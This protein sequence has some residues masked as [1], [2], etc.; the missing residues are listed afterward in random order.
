MPPASMAVA[1]STLNV[2]ATCK[3]R[4]AE[5]RCTGCKVRLAAEFY[6]HVLEFNN[7]FSM[8]VYQSISAQHYIYIYLSFYCIHNEQCSYYC[9]RECQVMHWKN[10][11]KKM[12]PALQTIMDG[13]EPSPIS[14][15]MVEAMKEEDLMKKVNMAMKEE[16]KRKMKTKKKKGKKKVASDDDEPGLALYKKGMDHVAG[17]VRFLEDYPDAELDDTRLDPEKGYRLIREAA[18]MGCK[19]AQYMLA[20]AYLEGE[21]P[22][23]YFFDQCSSEEAEKERAKWIKMAAE[24][25][26]AEACVTYANKFWREGE[27]GHPKDLGEAM[28]W[29][30]RAMVRGVGDGL[31]DPYGD[32]LSEKS[33]EQAQEDLNHIA[34]EAFLY[35]YASVLHDGHPDEEREEKIWLSAD[36][37]IGAAL[38]EAQTFVDA[39]GTTGQVGDDDE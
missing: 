29:L 4:C 23:G 28:V 10:G 27:C 22:S 24:N 13:Y 14:K 26:H 21:Y 31:P 38:V 34:R 3:K 19:G 36:C 1:L 11:H 20:L 9:S 30:R 25:G 15:K 12:C 18:E 17:A 32:A 6:H 8:Y 2:C 33:F 7:Y 35:K 16:K 5:K 39:E 37:G